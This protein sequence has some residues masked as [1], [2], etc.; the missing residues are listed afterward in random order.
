MTEDA[1]YVWYHDDRLSWDEARD[2][3]EQ[4]GQ[5]ATEEETEIHSM[6]FIIIA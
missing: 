2:Y 3:C 5:L 1:G 6:V 4:F